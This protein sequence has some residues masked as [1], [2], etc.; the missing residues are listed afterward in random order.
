MQASVEGGRFSH[1]G[2]IHGIHELS[3]CLLHANVT[4]LMPAT[5]GKSECQVVRPGEIVIAAPWGP[6]HNGWAFRNKALW[7]RRRELNLQKAKEYVKDKRYH[8]YHC[9]RSFHLY[10][11]FEKDD[12]VLRLCQN[13]SLELGRAR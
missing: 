1:A 7:V 4:P 12:T 13:L 10:M 2:S 5:L 6:L 8:H 3:Q 11:L 9:A